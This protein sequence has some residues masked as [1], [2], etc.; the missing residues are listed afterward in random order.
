MDLQRMGLQMTF[1]VLRVFRLQITKWPHKG[2]ARDVFQLV[3]LGVLV[4]PKDYMCGE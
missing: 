1:V 4:V 3:Q 2:G